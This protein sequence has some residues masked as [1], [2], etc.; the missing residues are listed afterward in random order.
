[1]SGITPRKSDTYF[2]APAA[3]VVVAATSVGIT[4][5]HSGV[6]PQA[7]AAGPLTGATGTAASEDRDGKKQ[8]DTLP[9]TWSGMSEG[10]AHSLSTSG[11]VPGRKSSL[12]P[13]PLLIVGSA[14]AEECSRTGSGSP[15]VGS[16]WFSTPDSPDIA[17]RTKSV[18]FQELSPAGRIAMMAAASGEASPRK[19]MMAQAAMRLSIQRQSGS[20]SEAKHS[21]TMEGSNAAKE[22]PEA[23]SENAPESSQRGAGLHM[24]DNNSPDSPVG[25][26][27]QKVL[28]LPSLLSSPYPSTFSCVGKIYF[29]LCNHPRLL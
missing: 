14:D 18:T 5:N 23:R 2:A 28:L 25:W 17:L 21:P 13:A 29:P 22:A 27:V 24:F 7:Q 1:M 9:V 16:R 4:G 11:R 10:V 8:Q 6:K 19:S 26:L 15:S 3:Q 12:R 20:F